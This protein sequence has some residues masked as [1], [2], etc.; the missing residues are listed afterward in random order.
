MRTVYIEQI[1][2]IRDDIMR[3]GKTSL[4]DIEQKINYTLLRAYE[5]SRRQN[6]P[7]LDFNN[8]IFD[9]DVDPIAD[10][11]NKFGVSAFTISVRTTSLID[12]L[13]KLKKKGFYVAGT[14]QFNAQYPD[15]RYETI[16]ALF[17]S[18]TASVQDDPLDTL[19]HLGHDLA[20]AGN[21][22]GLAELQRKLLSFALDIGKDIEAIAKK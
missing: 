21:I 2:K 7:Y 1:D 20:A 14:I 8:A 22:Q 9:D 5:D 6:K 10:T 4:K 3:E 11:L 17:L 12:I 19:K 16:D 13:V 15:R 18:S